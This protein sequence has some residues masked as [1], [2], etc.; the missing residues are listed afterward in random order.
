MKNYNKLSDKEKK[1]LLKKEYES[2]HKSFKDIAELCGTY[3]NK[4]RRDAIKFKINI[5]NKSEAQANAL[6][7]GKSI[8]PTKGQ[9]RP[10]SVKKQIGRTV[11]EKWENLDEKT[12]EARKEKAR[13]N[14]NN[15]SDDIKEHILQQANAAVREA[16]KRGSKLELFLLDNL[17][18][19]GYKVDFHKEQ[20]LSNTKLQIDLFLPKL[21]VAIEVDGLSHFEPVWGQQTLNRNKTYDNKKTGLILGKGLVLVRIKQLKD[22]SPSRASKI[23][24]KLLDVLSSIQKEYPK[25]DNRNIILGDY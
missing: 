14:W 21:N 24:S 22:F 13:K 23:Y 11:M 4:V 25:S 20:I 7:S 19:D 17:L 2:N 8:H 18:K 1:E 15:L 3:A 5:R 6:K 9:K 12:I 10:E 16:S